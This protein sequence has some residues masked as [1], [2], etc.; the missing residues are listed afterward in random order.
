[1]GRV[2]VLQDGRIPETNDGDSWTTVWT[3]LMPPDCTR[4]H[5][6]NGEFHDMH[7]LVPKNNNNEI[8]AFLQHYKVTQEQSQT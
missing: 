1:M 8:K 6:E 4:K 7:V 2:P 5:S 3:Y